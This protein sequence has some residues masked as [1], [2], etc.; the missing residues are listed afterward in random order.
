MWVAN[1][2]PSP[3]APLPMLGEGRHKR[4]VEQ[5]VMLSRIVLLSVS[6]SP[7]PALG[8]GP[9]VRASNLNFPPF[10]ALKPVIQYGQHVKRQQRTRQQAADDNCRQRFLHFGTSA[11]TQSHWQKAN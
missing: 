7:L 10:V 11:M 6:F 3:P 4:L 1:Y 8:E 9:G 5:I 2:W